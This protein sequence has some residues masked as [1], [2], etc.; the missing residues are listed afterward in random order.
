MCDMWNFTKEQSIKAELV[1]L[2]GLLETCVDDPILK[3]QLEE[4]IK[5]LEKEIGELIG[6]G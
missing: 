5:D 2:K 3:P 4:R 6:K 1:G